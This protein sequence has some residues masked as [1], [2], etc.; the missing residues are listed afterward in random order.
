MQRLDRCYSF[1]SHLTLLGN[2]MDQTPR[3]LGQT[4]VDGM[5]DEKSIQ[6]GEHSRTEKESFLLLQEL[7]TMLGAVITSL[8][9]KSL[10]PEV[11]YIACA[12][13]HVFHSAAGYHELR[14]RDNVYGSKLLIRPT[15]EAVFS[16]A[17]VCNNPS[18]LLEKAY[19]EHGEDLKLINEQETLCRKMLASRVSDADRQAMLTECARE[20]ESL[21]KGF[22]SFH[23]EFI[24]QRPEAKIKREKVS[25]MDAATDAHLESWYSRYRLYCQFTHGHLRAS[26]GALDSVTDAFAD[27]LVM[28]SLVLILLDHLKKCDIADVS[29]LGPYWARANAFLV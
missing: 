18:F 24:R 5:R 29:D 12:V 19:A 7:I 3:E 22:D 6:A 20:K 23:K 8:D 4:N 16:I 11:R 21:V 27:Y 10:L 14:K 9:G 13:V 26:S 28:I 2:I 1:C 25:A 15:M 17:A